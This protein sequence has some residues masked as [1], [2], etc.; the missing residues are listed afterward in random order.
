M[1]HQSL[2]LIPGV[3][4][5]KTPALN[6][7]A[8]SES[9]LVRFVPDRTLGGIVQKLGGW[10]KYISTQFN[11]IIRALHAWADT[12]ADSYLA[13]GAE[14][15]PALTVT[16]ATGTGT[17]VTLTYSGT[18]NLTVGYAIRVEGINPTAYNGTYLI[19]KIPGPNQVT[20]ASAVTTAYVSGGLIYGGGGAL[21]VVSAGSVT[22]ITPQVWTSNQTADFSTTAGSPVVTI[23]DPTIE[24]TPTDVVD[25]RTQV[26]VGG[27]VLY[28][29]YAINSYVSAN[30]YTII[31]R[32][33]FGDPVAATSTVVSGGAVPNYGT[34]I[35]SNIV[36]VT[37]ANHGYEVGNTFPA[38]I[39]TNVGGV[40]V[41][42][43]YIV[44]KVNNA[45]EFEI[46]VD[47]AARASNFVYE[48]G[49][50]VN[51]YYLRGIGPAY[52]NQGYGIGAYG[53][54][55]YGYGV[56]APAQGGVPINA[57][58]WCLDNWG[59]VLLSSPYGG[60]I[61]AWNPN[62][63]DQTAIAIANAPSANYGFFVA[64]PQ[65]QIVAWGSTQTGIIDPMLIRWCDVNN[66]DTWAPT[67]ENQAGSYRIPK[68]SHIV[69]CIQGPQQG[70]IWTNIGV[71]AMQYTGPPF[72]Y[73]FNEIGTGCGLIG[74]KA[75]TSL[76]GTIYWM[77]QNQFYRMSG[78]G[79]EP[80]KCP[81]WDVVF[82]DLD[83]DNVDKIRAAPNSQFG[84]VAWHFPILVNGVGT[85][86]NYGYVKYN[87]LLDQW[88][89][90]FNSD[91]SPYVARS[92]WINESVVGHPIGADLNRYLQ[93]HE[94]ST[95]ADG[96][97]MVSYFQTG[98]FV[99][100][101]ADVK[102]FV[103]QVWPDMKWGYY[104]GDQDAQIRL[105]FYVTDYAGAA[106]TV[107]G[108]YTLTQATTYI[109]P[110]FR[111]RLVSIRI[112]STDLGSFWRMGNI[113]YRLQPDGRF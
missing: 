76:N 106:P 62:S 52:G 63:G 102:M 78:T 22:D 32:D 91:A 109:T 51:F 34:T 45:N 112:E 13:V 29:Q 73:Q 36:V 38:R 103:D 8:V 3:D 48:N 47:L 11:S 72:V 33:I 9:Q 58:D 68:G 28:G 92:A 50:K 7:A 43:S 65:R 88:D 79:V 70:I 81:V 94:V 77:G 2:K 46:S 59:E 64:M 104:N 10:T 1:P 60:T 83:H 105:Y 95:D 21:S 108:P 53:A 24:V 96:S 6:E 23:V 101:E 15:S 110:R 18:S 54:G 66:Y 90:G 20:F 87:I 27:L 113:R 49:N 39:A 40:T 25:I 12:N 19:T 61:Y 100:S 71:W 57:T 16:N 55:A 89:Y 111:G 30:T 98:Y 107:Y 42:G 85:G 86:E 97:A 31:A 69:Q 4:Q 44:T 93:Q 17:E 75:A 74:H 99:L 37:L 41:Y 26:S 82:Q 35:N 5:T 67:I 84:E 14:G 80:L 56:V